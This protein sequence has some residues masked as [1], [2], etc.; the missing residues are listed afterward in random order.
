[1]SQTDVIDIE[2]KTVESVQLPS[3]FRCPIRFDLIQRAYV[4]LDTHSR[5]RQGRDPLAGERTTAETYNPPTGRG[6]SRI[7]RVKGEHYSRSGMGG[8]VASTVHGRLPFPPRAEK[9]IHKQINKKERRL[10]LASAIAATASHDL[11][12]LR[13]HLFSKKLPV[14]VSDEIEGI[15]RIKDIKNFLSSIGAGT[16]LTRVS[17]RSRRNR[18]RVSHGKRRGVGP[19]LVVS[20]SAILKPRLKSL[21]GVSVRRPSDLSVLD[22]APGSHPGRLTIWSK[23]AL[24]EIPAN[25][26]KIGERYAS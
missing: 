25:L 24:A 26:N 2:G 22:L 6:I 21:A 12:T 20:D 9:N 11:V 8:G 18:P 4:S 15:S 5:Q 16:E 19:L 17:N 1:M 14:I 23:K 10:A 13:G 7:P 3:V